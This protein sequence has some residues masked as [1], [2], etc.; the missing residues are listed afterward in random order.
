M[1]NMVAVILAGFLSVHA[2]VHQEYDWAIF[3]LLL[4]V[5]NG[6]MALVTSRVVDSCPPFCGRGNSSTTESKFIKI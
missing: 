2:S 5:L 1:I 3:F 6:A 4:S